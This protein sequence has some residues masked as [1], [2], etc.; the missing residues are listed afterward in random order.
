MAHAALDWPW[1]RK[2]VAVLSASTVVLDKFSETRLSQTNFLL[3]YTGN[4]WLSRLLNELECTICSSGRE[5]RILTAMQWASN[6]ASHF[7]TGL[8]T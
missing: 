7:F 5:F 1:R 2:E 8:D 4:L 3:E 6:A